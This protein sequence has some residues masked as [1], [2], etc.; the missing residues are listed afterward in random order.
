[1]IGGINMSK[2]N[3]VNHISSSC[4]NLEMGETVRD[5]QCP[6]C[7]R[8]DG[9]FA[10]TRIQEG[11]LYRC[12]RVKCDKSGIV[13]SNNGEWGDKDGQ[14]QDKVVKKQISKPYPFE[15]DI[16]PLSD[17][18]REFLINNFKFTNKDIKNNKIKW[19]DATGRIIYPI[20]S[21]EGIT[22]GYVARYYME[23]AKTQSPNYP[24][25]KTYWTNKEETDPSIAFAYTKSAIKASDGV[26]TYVLVEDIPSAIR[27]SKYIPSIALISNCIPYNALSFLMGKN[28]GIMLDNDATEQSI[29]LFNKYSLFFN[30]C[31]VIPIGMDPKNMP[32]DMLKKVVAS[33]ELL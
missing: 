10:V 27:L 22:K 4:I 1:M 14:W 28:I 15:S 26:D 29:K 5:I 16:I 12:F 24:K 33:I 9:D 17:S 32:E 8:E 2:F 31:Q 23:I 25:A 13:K 18:Q 20:L 11:L 30:K 6:F 3:Y 21:K 19:C 7:L